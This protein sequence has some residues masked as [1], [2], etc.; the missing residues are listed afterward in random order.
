MDG[1][2]MHAQ[3]VIAATPLN[4]GSVPSQPCATGRT[5][6][7][8]QTLML[9]TDYRQREIP[10]QT[11]PTVGGNAGRAYLRMPPPAQCHRPAYWSHSM[12]GV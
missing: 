5:F 8:Q 10:I 4:T 6:V 3:I 9:Q 11:A 2:R 7:S 12:I 1:V